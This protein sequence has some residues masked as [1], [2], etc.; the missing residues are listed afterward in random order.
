M[1]KLKVN[2]G[3]LSGIHF[4]LTLAWIFGLLASLA[5]VTEPLLQLIKSEPHARSLR[6]AF[7][8]FLVCSA[9]LMALGAIF[10]PECPDC[11]LTPRFRKGKPTGRTRKAGMAMV[12]VNE[13]DLFIC[14]KCGKEWDAWPFMAGTHE[15]SNSRGDSTST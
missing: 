7:Y 15:D 1:K 14:P 6:P 5:W 2:V 4:I 8:F 13:P 12:G 10:I 11:R 3:V 9:L